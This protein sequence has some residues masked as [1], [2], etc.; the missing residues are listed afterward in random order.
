MLTRRRRLPRRILA[1]ALTV[2]G[3]RILISPEG[4]KPTTIRAVRRLAAALDH[5][6]VAVVVEN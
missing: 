1:I 3:E 2:K 5:M 4:G 6:D